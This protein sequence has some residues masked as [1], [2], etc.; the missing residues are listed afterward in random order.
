MTELYFSRLLVSS[1]A[2]DLYDIHERVWS[3]FRKQQSA[4]ERRPFLF[5]ADRVVHDSHRRAWKVLV[6]STKPADWS[7]LDIIEHEQVG[8]RL[9]ALQEGERLRFYLRANVTRASLKGHRFDDLPDEV[10]RK[11]RGLRVAVRQ[12]EALLQWLVR[13]ADRCGFS[14]GN[15]GAEAAGPLNV[16]IVAK[17]RETWNDGGRHGVH[18]GVDFEGHL[19]VTNSALLVEGMTAGFGKAKAFGFGLLSLSRE[20]PV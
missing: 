15:A 17:H 13:K 3:G 18:E 9:V 11:T 7:R 19:M 4:E 14:L 1:A 2:R 8:P 6:Q 16:R 5:R 20:I 12:D 10:R